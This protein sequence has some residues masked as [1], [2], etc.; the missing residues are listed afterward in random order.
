MKPK[1]EKWYRRGYEAGYLDGVAET[2]DGPSKGDPVAPAVRM[3][4]HSPATPAHP[5]T[6][7]GR[8]R[9]GDDRSD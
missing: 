6:M 3:Y 2:R 1:K 7:I 8:K 5:N 9:Q 4:Q